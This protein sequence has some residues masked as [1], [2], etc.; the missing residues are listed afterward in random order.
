MDVVAFVEYLRLMDILLTAAG[1]LAFL[2]MAA[3]AFPEAN[4]A[5]CRVPAKIT[6]RPGYQMPR[7]E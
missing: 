6:R 7:G 1:L 5:E 4:R 2:G 3:S